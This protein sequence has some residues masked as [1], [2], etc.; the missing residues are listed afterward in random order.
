M[1]ISK[2]ARYTTQSFKK[3]EQVGDPYTANTPQTGFA[4]CP[5][6]KSVY[7]NKRW[8]LPHPQ[9]DTIMP[10]SPRSMRKSGNP[11]MMPELFVCPAC[12]KIRDGYAEGFVSI[13]WENWLAHKADI[14]GLIHNEEKRASHVNPLERIMAVH[15]RSNG[16]DVETTTERMAQRIGRD[17]ARAFKG[18]VQYKWSHKDKVARV[19]WKGPKKKAVSRRT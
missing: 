16:I 17:L 3:K 14:I 15:T 4:I 1:A 7:Y 5:E 18:K 8:A 13:R 10:K 19:Q 11:V 9:G 6:C 2:T 12:Q